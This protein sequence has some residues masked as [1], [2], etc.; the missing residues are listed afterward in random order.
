VLT[1]LKVAERLIQLFKINTDTASS[2]DDAIEK[3]KEND[4]QNNLINPET[5]FKEIPKWNK[6]MGY[7]NYFTK[8]KGKRKDFL[9]YFHSM[10]LK[11]EYID[12]KGNDNYIY[13][14]HYKLFYDDH[15]D[16][17]N[18]YEK[19]KLMWEHYPIISKFEIRKLYE[20]FPT[21]EGIKILIENNCL[22]DDIILS[23][24]KY[25]D[26]ET[27]TLM[28]GRGYFRLKIDP[29]YFYN[30]VDDILNEYGKYKIVSELKELLF[31]NDWYI[32]NVFSEELYN[33]KKK[34]KDEFFKKIFREAEN[35]YRERN[36]KFLIGEKWVGETS[37]YYSLCENFKGVEIKK[38]YSPSWLGRQHL[39]IYF[40]LYNIAVEYQGEQHDKPIDFFGGLSSFIEN[41]KRDEKKKSLCN[42]NG[43]RLFEYRKGDSL[44]ELIISIKNKIIKK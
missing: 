40:P 25:L 18:L 1:N 32:G 43:C 28:Y 11:G 2:A 41:K 26:G 14:L 44:E 27:F 29:S 17:H 37:L 13:A 33:E 38:N 9:D 8:I 24:I 6:S 19:L 35:R 31:K 12:L 22:F 10:F 36:G 4:Y 20:L 15:R 16:P 34:K 21:D 5:Y 7:V 3:V 30:D 39:D 42:A 23:N